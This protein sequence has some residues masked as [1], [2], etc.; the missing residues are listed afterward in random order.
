MYRQAITIARV[1]V[2]QRER[3]VGIEDA[4]VKETTLSV[5]QNVGVVR[6]RN[7]VKIG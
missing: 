5:R 3:L 6:E 1:L 2:V 7:P 4:H